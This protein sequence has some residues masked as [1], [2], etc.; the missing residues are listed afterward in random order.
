MLL[1]EGL[2]DG[3]VGDQ[4]DAMRKMHRKVNEMQHYMYSKID[5]L[6]WLTETSGAN[7]V[8][9]NDEAPL[10]EPMVRR[11]SELDSVGSEYGTDNVPS[12]C[13]N[14]CPERS[15]PLVPIPGHLRPPP[16]SLL[17]QETPDSGSDLQAGPGSCWDSHE[18][19]VTKMVTYHYHYRG[20]HLP[21][22]S[23]DH[24]LLIWPQTQFAQDRQN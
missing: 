24:S 3:N 6:C 16:P 19:S 9:L 5:E 20:E 23:H 12:D 22:Y 7:E 13:S 14:S 17:I 2:K 8:D 4:R 11:L 1:I 10:V 15:S 18:I 21:N